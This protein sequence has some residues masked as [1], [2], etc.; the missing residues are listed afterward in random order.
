MT[1]GHDGKGLGAGW[2]LDRVVVDDAE[3]GWRWYFPCDRW[4]DKSEDD[5]CTERILRVSK[6]IAIKDDIEEVFVVKTFTGHV[7]GAGTD[8]NIYIEMYGEDESSGTIPLEKSQHRNKFEKGQMDEVTHAL[9]APHRTA[10]HR[11]RARTHA[12]MHTR[13][14][15]F[16]C[17]R[18]V[19]CARSGLGTTPRGS[20][21]AGTSMKWSSTTTTRRFGITSNV[22]RG[23]TRM[24]AT[25]RSSVC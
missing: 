3:L 5:G 22:T 2:Y 19:L 17:G 9:T 24:R 11:M 4:L 7:R 14:S 8:A 16:R 1:I 20:A 21:L 15:R 12:R 10:P 13:S 23:W 18:S 6:S 25:A